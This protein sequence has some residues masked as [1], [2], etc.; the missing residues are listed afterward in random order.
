MNVAIIGCG[1][2]ATNHMKAVLNNGLRL[3]AICDVLPDAMERL[4]IKH[5]LEKVTAIKRYTNYE[6]MLSEMQIDL[7]GICTESGLH[8]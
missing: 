3:V 6:T 8:A 1:R 7:V 2:I 5:E 4:L